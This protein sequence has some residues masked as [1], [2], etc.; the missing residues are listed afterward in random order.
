[1][2]LSHQ[3]QISSFD[4]LG[5]GIKHRIDRSLGVSSRRVNLINFP[6]NP[7]E[8]W[9][10]MFFSLKVSWEVFDMSIQCFHVIYLAEQIQWTREQPHFYLMLSLKVLP[11][12]KSTRTAMHNDLI[13]ISRQWLFW[14]GGHGSGLVSSSSEWRHWQSV[15]C[16][17]LKK[18]QLSLPADPFPIKLTRCSF[19]PDEKEDLFL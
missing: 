4:A 7:T 2:L 16:P 15:D 8:T 11:R 10:K 14:K 17:L 3:G 1:M 5:K 18:T 6:I 13:N 12:D 19:S 9:A